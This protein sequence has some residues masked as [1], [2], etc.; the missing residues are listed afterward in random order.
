MAF[1]YDAAVDMAAQVLKQAEE[2]KAKEENKAQTFSGLANIAM[3]LDT[4][5]LDLQTASLVKGFQSGFKGFQERKQ[6]RID[7]AQEKVDEAKERYEAELKEQRDRRAE[8]FSKRLKLFAGSMEGFE[9]AVFGGAP[10]VS[11]SIA[12]G[13]GSK[14]NTKAD[15]SKQYRG[16]KLGG[17]L[18]P[19]GRKSGDRSRGSKL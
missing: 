7:K 15:P 16:S 11:E 12:K 3:G 10:S 1:N 14:L 19:I 13:V 18:G 8:T 6:K 2:Q 9:E 17:M 5:G 4:E